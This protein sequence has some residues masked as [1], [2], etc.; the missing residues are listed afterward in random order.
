[1]IFFL[2]FS[3]MQLMFLNLIPNHILIIHA[4]GDI[5]RKKKLLKKQV[6][7]CVNFKCP[8]IILKLLKNFILYEA[9]SID[10]EN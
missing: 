1:M 7:V 8:D 9:V 10:T 5:T 4:G 3:E 6:Q 2:Y